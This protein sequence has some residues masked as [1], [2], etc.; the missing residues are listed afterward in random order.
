MVS[1]TSESVG[2]ILDF[3]ER[4]VKQRLSAPVIAITMVYVMQEL[5]SVDPDMQ[6]RIAHTRCLH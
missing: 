1:V 2:V 4:L 5:V 6:G 3:L